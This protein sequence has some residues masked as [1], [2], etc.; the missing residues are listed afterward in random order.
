MVLAEAARAA[1]VRRFVF[2]SSCSNYG[3]AGDDLLTE[4]AP[5][6]PVTPYGRSKVLAEQDLRG[7]AGSGF[8]PVFMRNA[9]A[10]GV[11]PRLRCDL[12][13]NNLTAW[14]AT[15]GRVLIKSDGAAWRPLV[16]AED[17]CRAFRAALDAPETLVHNQAF[18]VGQTAEN[19]RVRELAEVVR[20]TVP[21]CE[22]EYSPGGAPDPRNYRVDC[23]KVGRM[24]PAFRPRWTAVSG[25][26]QLYDAY[27][28]HSLKLEDFEG[29]RYRRI[30]RIRSLLADGRLAPDLRWAGGARNGFV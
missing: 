6:N 27:V 9:T 7:L 23:D 21:G 11:S 30:D 4:E 5:L 3:A 25:A 15:S 26:R 24:L 1:D 22:I 29:P 28:D 20:R 2:S 10:Y 16:H 8:H 17:I 14:A 13:L 12:V 19:Y 18:N